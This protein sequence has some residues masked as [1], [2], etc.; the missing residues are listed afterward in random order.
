MREMFAGCEEEELQKEE[1]GEEKNQEFEKAWDMVKQG[2][3]QEAAAKI[4]QE[5][6]NLSKQFD[7]SKSMDDNAIK[8]GMEIRNQLK[9]LRESGNAEL[10]DKLE[11]MP[12]FKE[13]LNLYQGQANLA[14]MG[15]KGQEARAQLAEKKEEQK[16]L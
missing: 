6:Q 2:N 8:S 12:E 5:M 1:K 11:S 3:H 13:N 15:Q 14:E 4:A 10:I 16:V 7:Q 9:R